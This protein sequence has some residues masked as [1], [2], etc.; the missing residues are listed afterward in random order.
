MLG[1][2]PFETVRQQHHQAAQPPPLGL[3]A[4]DELVDDHLGRVDK[5][6][7]LRFPQ[8]QAVGAIDAVA[9]FEAQHAGFAQRAVVNLERPL[10]FAQVLEG[11]VAVAVLIIVQHGMP[12]AERAPG[13]VL[14]A[15]ADAVPFDA[16]RGKGQGLGRRPIERLF[17]AAHFRSL[18]EELDDLGMRMEILRQRR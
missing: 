14:A 6:A 2:L 12:L 15:H 9:I 4:G 1:P 18:L 8:D 11:H 10:P 7:E 17:A 13:A 16:Q 5:V 3:G